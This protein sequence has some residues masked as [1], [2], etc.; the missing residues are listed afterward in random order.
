MLADATK[1]RHGRVYNK[2]ICQTQSGY[3][4]LDQLMVYETE[5]T[6]AA[7]TV[8]YRIKIHNAC[9]HIAYIRVELATYI[10]PDRNSK[11]E[12]SQS[13]EL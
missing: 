3:T 8:E 12:D 5:R 7:D 11:P 13:P 4:C 9:R 1:P 2:C 6:P 10:H